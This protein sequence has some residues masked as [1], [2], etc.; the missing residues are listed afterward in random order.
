MFGKFS[1][2]GLIYELRLMM[3]LSGSNRGFAFIQF[4]NKQ[5]ATRAIAMMHNYEMR[6][7]HHIGVVKSI[8]N[9]RIYIGGIPKNKTNED[10]QT[11]ME[12]L[13]E[14]V[15]KVIVYR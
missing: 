6:P 1:Q 2:I 12:R 11:E 8:D 15:T 3:H 5:E 9:C 10:I 4:A 13:T 7:Q 14:G